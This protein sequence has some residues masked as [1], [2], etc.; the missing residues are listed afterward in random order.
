M[1]VEM[2]PLENAPCLRDNLNNEM[3]MMSAFQENIQRM[4]HLEEKI[5]ELNNLMSEMKDAENVDPKELEELQNDFK[6][7]E[8]RRT[9]VNNFISTEKER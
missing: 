4:D 3:L 7:F 1:F 5:T 2:A 8:S 9:H 6:D